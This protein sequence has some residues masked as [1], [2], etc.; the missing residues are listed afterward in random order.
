MR[1]DDIGLYLSPAN[2]ARLDAI[3]KDRN[4]PAKAIWRAGIVLATADGCGTN[5]K[6]R[7]SRVRL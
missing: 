4:S 1:R 7:P 5:D 6:T 3:I 2:R